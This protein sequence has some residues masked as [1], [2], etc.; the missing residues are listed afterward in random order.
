MIQSILKILFLTIFLLIPAKAVEK[1]IIKDQELLLEKFETLNWLNYENPKEGYIEYKKSNSRFYLVESEFYLEGVDANQYCWWSFGKECQDTDFL[2]FGEDYSIYLSYYDEGFVKIDD[3]KDVN[4]KQWL[5]EMREI[6]NTNAEIFKKDGL[7]Y[8]NNINWIFEPTFEDDRKIVTYSKE[9]TWNNNLTTMEANAI[10]L[11]RKGYVDALFVFTIKDESDLEDNA[12]FGKEFA[13]AIE[14]NENFRHS[15]YK[16]GDKVAAVGIGS[17]VAGTLG[18]KALAKAGA[19]A[20]L[21]GIVAKF[22]W[23]ILAALVG[24]GGLF[25]KKSNSN[26][27]SKKKTRSKKID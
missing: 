9:V 25:G 8:V 26:K 24:L 13:E 5:K 15:D 17:L 7:D 1:K 18:V 19:F 16:S 27:T 22:W 20:K 10:A 4:T 6:A 12:K 11:G 3:W 14:F 2:I 21:L 23:V